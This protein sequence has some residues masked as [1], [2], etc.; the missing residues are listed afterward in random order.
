MLFVR[1]LQND[2]FQIALQHCKKAY[3]SFK[4][5]K[6]HKIYTEFD[7]MFSSMTHALN[8]IKVTLLP[9]KITNV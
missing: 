8:V 4:V 5:V 2:T 7:R 1:N 9:S 3:F 6:F